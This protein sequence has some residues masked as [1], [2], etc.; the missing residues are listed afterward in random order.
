[1]VYHNFIKPFWSK[2]LNNRIMHK[3]ISARTSQTVLVT[4]YE[5]FANGEKSNP[6]IEP[7]SQVVILLN[8]LSLSIGLFP[9]QS[10]ISLNMVKCNQETDAYSEA[11][12]KIRTIDQ[13]VGLL[14]FAGQ[15]NIQEFQFDLL[16]SNIGVWHNEKNE[17]IIV[18]IGESEKL[19]FELSVSKLANS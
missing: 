1:M 7:N 11:F 4:R 9:G 15:N 13:F 19:A 6:I 16:D 17:L 2:R 10:K 3:R 18:G 12:E 14:R 8:A 5:V